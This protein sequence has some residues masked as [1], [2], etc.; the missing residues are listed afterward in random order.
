MLSQFQ[1]TTAVTERPMTDLEA[2]ASRFFHQLI[3]AKSEFD[4]ACHNLQRAVERRNSADV[5]LRQLT[6]QAQKILQINL[7]DPTEE[8]KL[9]QNA[10]ASQIGPAPNPGGTTGMLRR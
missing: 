6:D 10:M 2:Q 3:E 4:E 9:V 8:K 7:Q 5:L 1:D